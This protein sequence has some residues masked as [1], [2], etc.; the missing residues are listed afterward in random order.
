MKL[1][2]SDGTGRTDVPLK[3]LLQRPKRRGIRAEPFEDEGY[4]L[5]ADG[6]YEAYFFDDPVVEAQVRRIAEV[7]GLRLIDLYF[8]HVEGD[9]H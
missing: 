6:V 8:D 5:S 1:R 9:Y 3:N 2:K 4:V 7:F